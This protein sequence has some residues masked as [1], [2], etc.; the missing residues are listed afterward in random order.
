MANIHPF[1]PAD[2]AAGYHEIISELEHLLAEITGFD[3]VSLQPNSGAAG[4]YTG[5]MVIREYHLSHGDSKRNVVLIPSSAHGTNPAS[6]AMAGMQV[7]VVACDEMGNINVDDLKAKAEQ[8]RETLSAFM[9][10]YPQ[11]TGFL[12][13]KSVKW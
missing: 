7:V 5:L 8:Y 9:V 13:V 12:K 6:A 11:L 2:Q 3:S 10:T 4:E 1:V